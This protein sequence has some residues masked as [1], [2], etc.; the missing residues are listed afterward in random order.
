MIRDFSLK[1]LADFLGAKLVGA[2]QQVNRVITDSRIAKEGD[3]FVA[4]KGERL[5]AHQFV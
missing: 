4:L 3:L 5:D 1:E 2:D